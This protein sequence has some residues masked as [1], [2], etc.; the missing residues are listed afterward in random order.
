MRPGSFKGFGSLGTRLAAAFVG[1]AL[2][3]TAIFAAVTL[4]SQ[5]S[6]V[7]GLATSQQE[8][9]AGAVI[10]ALASAYRANAGWAGANLQPAVVLVE[11]AGAAVSVRSPDGAA[12]LTSGEL[13]LLSSPSASQLHK[14]LLVDNH[15]VAAVHLAFPQGGLGPADVRLRSALL[16][17][18]GISAGLAVLGALVVAL[19]TSRALLRPIHRMSAAARALEAGARDARVGDRQGPGELGELARSFDAMAATLERNEQLRRAMVADVAHELRTPIAILQA[20]TEALVDG[21]ETADPEALSSLHEEAVRIGGLVD[22]L[23]ALSS[24]EAAGLSL[25]R[26][27]A[28]LAE[29]ARNAAG[30][31]AGRFEAGDVEL[32]LD[33]SPAV[34]FGDPQRLHQVVTNL[35]SNAAKFTPPGGHVSVKVGTGGGEA[36]LAVADSG[37]GVLEAERDRIFERF[38]RGSAGKR[39]GGTGIGLAV[40][41]ELV[42][43]HGGEVLLQS[44]E[45]GGSTFVVRLV[46]AGSPL[47][48]SPLA[49]EP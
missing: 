27:E 44:P 37:P 9:T 32:S 6:D 30:S 25:H 22:D 19:V 24:A 43:A 41:K 46:L 39:A 23:Q 14:P 5:S 34:V 29:I 42:R 12:L 20:H 38:Y 13:S 17:A 4:S 10:S 35:L 2:V 48:G 3:A 21:I 36:V 28:D 47:A 11:I 16:E 31:L 33:L 8:R 15:P 49:A 7:A 26:E 40:V 45:N 18:V 1:V